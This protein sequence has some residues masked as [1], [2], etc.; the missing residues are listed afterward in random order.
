VAG[1]AQ[2]NTLSAKS[3]AAAEC[4]VGLALEWVMFKCWIGRIGFRQAAA[5][6]CV[7]LLAVT[8][9]A[10][11]VSAGDGRAVR[12]VVA[13]QLKAFANDRA[14]LAFS[15]AAPAI[16]QQFGDA[17]VF[18]AMVRQSYAM[19][20]RP[21][22]VSY[23]RPEGA[24]GVITQGVQFRDEEGK[25]WRAVYELQRQSDKRWRISGCVVEP[26]DE[27]SIT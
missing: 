20:I 13:A 27:S 26:G 8:A 24:G 14:E 3:A 22:S 9:N 7:A 25:L 16:R 17:K 2:A 5:A 18:M 19:L 15:Y 4:A 21:R 10:E 23:F 6:V 11:G 1:A 12:A